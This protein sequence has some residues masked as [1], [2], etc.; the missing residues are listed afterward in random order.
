MSTLTNINGDVMEKITL[1]NFTDTPSD[2]KLMHKWCSQKEIYEWFEQRVLSYN[3]IV[4]KYQNKLIENK[5]KLFLIYYDEKPIG[6]TQI[7]KYEDNRIPVLD[8]YHNIYEYDIFIG[9]LS[10]LSKGIGSKIV[11]IVNDYIYHNYLADCIIL[12]PFKSNNRAI[13]CYQKNKFH[14]IYEYTDYNT[15]GNKENIVVLIN[16]R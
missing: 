7:Y 14:I 11:E 5:Q 13:K 8:N 2:Y 10:Y 6:F 12:R 16:R 15:V 4:T 1:H 9:E 3:E